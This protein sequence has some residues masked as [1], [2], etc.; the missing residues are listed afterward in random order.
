MSATRQ[1]RLCREGAYLLG[2][3]VFVLAGAWVHQISLLFVVGGLMLGPLLF[4]WPAVVMALRNLRIVRKFP[5][6]IGAG[7]LLV[8]RLEAGLLSENSSFR[9]TG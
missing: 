7:E 6:A 9:G 3:V 5:A 1:T 8:V 4:H 2:V